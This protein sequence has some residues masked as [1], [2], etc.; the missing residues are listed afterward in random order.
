MSAMPKYVMDNVGRDELVMLDGIGATLTESVREAMADAI[1]HN[2]PVGMI[3]GFSSPTSATR[4]NRL[5]T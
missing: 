3:A 5:C 1:L 4:W 2:D